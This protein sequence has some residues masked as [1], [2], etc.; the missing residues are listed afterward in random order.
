MQSVSRQWK[1]Q[2]MGQSWWQHKRIAINMVIEMQYILCMLGVPIDGP[3]LM[4]G[5]NN[6]MMVLNTLVSS[7]MLKKKHHVCTYHCVRE[8]I[9]GGIINFMH[10]RSIK[11]LYRYA[12]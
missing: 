9:A 1:P 11:Q 4:L 5:D 2:P 3:A 6:S 8:A 10:I 7:S 12:E